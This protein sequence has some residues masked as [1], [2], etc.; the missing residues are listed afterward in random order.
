MK[1]KAAV[2]GDLARAGADPHGGA[3]DVDTD[4]APES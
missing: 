3:Q 2:V 1:F 4:E